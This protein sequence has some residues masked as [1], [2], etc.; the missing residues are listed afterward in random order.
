MQRKCPLNAD[1]FLLLTAKGILVVTCGLLPIAAHA[2]QPHLPKVPPEPVATPRSLP[3]DTAILSNQVKRKAV[4]S[5]QSQIRSTTGVDIQSPHDSAA[6]AQ[7]INQRILE[8]KAKNAYTKD[9]PAKVDSSTVEDIQVK[10]KAKAEEALGKELGIPLSSIPRRDSI[11]LA[12]LAAQ[13]QHVVEQ[14]ARQAGLSDLTGS[15]PLQEIKQ[16][17]PDLEVKAID[18]ER[19]AQQAREKMVSSAKSY[20]EAH[21]S[22]ISAAQSQMATLKRK[23]SSVPNSNDLSTAIKRISLKGDSIRHR[24]VPGFN[25]TVIGTSP[26]DFDFAPVLG[27]RVNRLFTAGILTN[28]G[29]RV[30]TTQGALEVDTRRLGYG[31]YVTHAFFRGL[32]VYAELTSI[33]VQRRI[34]DQVTTHWIQPLLIGAGKQL[35]LSKSISA[36]MLVT[37]NLFYSRQR[38]VYSSPLLF[39]TALRFGRHD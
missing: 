23:Y 34:D 11:T 26:V 29:L 31:A 22:E 16:A 36:Q 4:D 5:A 17:A 7:Q 18:L 14:R 13:G 2:Q 37:Y 32:F 9:L 25:I 30:Q 28:V 6:V 20:V 27:F 39:K 38:D 24:F 3:V 12:K 33:H 19:A 10:T 15:G 8:A 21:A 1:A 35:A